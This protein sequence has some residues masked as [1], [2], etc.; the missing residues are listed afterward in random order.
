MSILKDKQINLKEFD[1]FDYIEAIESLDENYLLVAPGKKKIIE[2][3][4][5]HC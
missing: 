5:H 2:D 1:H 4:L 3:F